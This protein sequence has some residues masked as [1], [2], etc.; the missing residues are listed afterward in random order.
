VTYTIIARAFNGDLFDDG[1]PTDWAWYDVMADD[2]TLCIC[3]DLATAERIVRA[4]EN[5]R[6][7]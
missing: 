3:E 7:H 2:A 6:E 4:L 5:Y 1:Q